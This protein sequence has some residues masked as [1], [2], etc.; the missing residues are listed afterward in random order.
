M[1]HIL[2]LAISLVLFVTSFDSLPIECSLVIII[3]YIC[4]LTKEIK[5]YRGRILVPPYLLT[6]YVLV[7]IV[8][9]ALAIKYDMSPITTLVY[10]SFSDKELSQCIYIS[11]IGVASCWLSFSLLLNVH[12]P[13]K[14]RVEFRIE[15][16]RLKKGVLPVVIILLI[17]LFGLVVTGN[18]GYFAKDSGSSNYTEKIYQFLLL[19][20]SFYFLYDNGTYYKKRL[21][22]YLVVVAISLLGLISG[23][24]TLLI[25]PAFTLYV[26]EST[27]TNNWRNKYLKMVPILFAAA[28]ILIIPI[29]YAIKMN[30]SVS[31][32]ETADLITNNAGDRTIVLMVVSDVIDRA[33]YVPVLSVALKHKGYVP[34]NVSKLWTYTLLSPIYAFVPRFLFPDKPSNTFSNWYAYNLM[35]ST[36]ENHMSAS[37]QGILFMNGGALSVIMG[38]LLVGCLFYLLYCF[39]FQEKYIYIYL[40]QIMSFIVLP[41]EPWAL[42]VATIQSFVLYYI[43]HKLI[44]SK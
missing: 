37:Y 26:I 3:P 35:G 22:Y 40:A 17:V 39:Y 16:A 41:A 9:G 28:F 33:N 14:D 19:I 24:K 6:L 31:T 44:A 8:L 4:Y 42:Y 38:F 11:L 34:N 12:N 5:K 2:V 15:P 1:I 25:L 32:K 13:F 43:L 27:K 23:S 10:G 7:S 30:E 29:R 36:E 20:V 21:F 18:F